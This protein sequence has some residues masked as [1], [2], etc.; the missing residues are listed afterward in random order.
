MWQALYQDILNQRERWILWLPVSFGAGILTYY[1]LLS[2]PPAALP[3]ILIGIA[4]FAW[5]I[6]FRRAHAALPFMHMLLGLAFGFAMAQWQAHR[7]ADYPVLSEPLERVS[8]RA[9]VKELD[10]RPDGNRLWLSNLDIWRKDIGKLPEDKT[11]RYARLNIRTEMEDILPGDRVYLRGSLSPPPARPVYPGGYDFSRYAFFQQIGAVGYSISPV[12]HRDGSEDVLVDFSLDDALLSQL[13]SW[14]HR[15]STTILNALEHTETAAIATALLTGKR[16]GITEET[17]EA[18]RSA[19]VGHLLAISGLHIA[20]VMMSSYFVVRLFLAALPGIALHYPIK[21]IAALIALGFGFIY[22]LL[23]GLP[24]SA[25]R[26]YV[27]AA[28]FFL[29]ILLD[30]TGLPMRP[31]AW[32]AMVVMLVDPYA[33][34][35]P[36]FH[37]SFAAVVALVAA[38][39]GSRDRIY[40]RENQH[41]FRMVWLYVGGVLLSTLVAGTA[42]SVYAVA[43]FGRYAHYSLLANLLAIPLASFWIMPWGIIALVLMPLGLA[44]IPLQMMGVGITYLVQFAEFIAGLSHSTRLMPVIAGWAVGTVTIGALWLC[45]WRRRVRYVG[46]VPI[47]MGLVGY[48]FPPSLP[49]V[50]IDEDASLVALRTESGELAFSSLAR[51]RYDRSQWLQAYGQEEPIRIRDLKNDATIITTDYG[52]RYHHIAIITNNDAAGCPDADYVISLVEGACERAFI[53]VTN[54]REEGAHALWLGSEL[55]V[56]TSAEY[57]GTRLWTARAGKDNIASHE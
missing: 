33:I 38:F 54:L 4:F 24:I 41:I 35:T 32:A 40:R 18:L 19:G 2:E 44:D 52:Y 55:R 16:G 3:Y 27:M 15:V 8:I 1:S 22:L 45:L 30:R 12:R 51:A 57:Q 48:L 49:D 11:P 23:A 47:A 34:T 14:R 43:H 29:A 39:E 28:L 25:Q 31:V 7:A 17:N 10:L 13:A 21:K 42:T 26:A 9:T 53:S 50:L 6:C 56:E 20:L 36:S 37:M 5:V 46:L